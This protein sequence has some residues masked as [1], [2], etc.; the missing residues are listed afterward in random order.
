MSTR[1][2]RGYGLG[3]TS[4]TF[5]LPVPPAAGFSPSL[6]Y[7]LPVAGAFSANRVAP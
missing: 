1:I 5:V 4:S 6:L 2:Q 7:S 3:A